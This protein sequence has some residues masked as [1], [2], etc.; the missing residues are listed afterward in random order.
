MYVAGID[1]HATYLMVAVVSNDGAIVQKP[2]RISNGEQARLIELLER[3]QPLDVVVEA[4]SAWPWLFD[5][6][7]TA[8]NRFVLAHPKK[9]RAIAESNYKSDAIDA[10]LLARMHLARLI[11][12]VYC[13]PIEQ[14][15]QAVLVRHRARLVRL[16]TQ[17]ASR[18]HAEIHGVGLHLARGRMLTREGRAWVRTRAWPLLGPEQRRLIESHEAIID[19]L[20]RRIRVLDKQVEAMAAEIPAVSVLRTVPGIG[21]YRGLL[22]A[23]EAMPIERF[24]KPK[25]LVSY[26]G[27]APRSSRSGMSV[28]YGS[29]PAGANR[30][31]RNAFVQTVVVHRRRS[32][33]SWLSQYYD[34]LKARLDW[35]TA[36][37]ASARKLARAV[38]AMLRTGEVWRE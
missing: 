25:H 18:I 8:V 22:I 34:Q 19:H 32:P 9:L 29:I 1:A 27:L 33:E 26:A 16:R 38:H 24:S 3:Y 14:R 31:L 6:T 5:L 7:A 30:W 20:K 2:I 35:R 37:V 21:S 4:S 11:P 23:T 17:A 36:R 28:R 10:T 13:K 15:E 12:E